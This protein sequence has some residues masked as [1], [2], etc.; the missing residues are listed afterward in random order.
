MNIYEDDLA[1]AKRLED[2][3][4]EYNR[5]AQDAINKGLKVDT[6]VILVHKV[7]VTVTRVINTKGD[8]IC[9]EA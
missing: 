5:V 6:S 2:L 9:Q 7:S 4:A 8:Q 3:A 1:F